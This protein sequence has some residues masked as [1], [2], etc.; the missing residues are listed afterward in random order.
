[1]HG[2]YAQD[3]KENRCLCI[4]NPLWFRYEVRSIHFSGAGFY[5]Q[6]KKKS[7]KDYFFAPAVA[8]LMDSMVWSA[9]STGLMLKLT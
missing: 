5:G 4:E 3:T 1:M 9:V 6:N 8:C 7:D 2:G